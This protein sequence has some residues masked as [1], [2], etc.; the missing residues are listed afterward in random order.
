MP[1]NKHMRPSENL[2][3]WKEGVVADLRPAWKTRP[4][5]MSSW[6]NHNFSWPLLLVIKYLP[7]SQNHILEII[8][9]KKWQIKHRSFSELCDIWKNEHFVICVHELL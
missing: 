9:D 1:L 5:L 7:I 2:G 8:S 3:S 6:S 4:L